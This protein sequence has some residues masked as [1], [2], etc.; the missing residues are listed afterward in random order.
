MKKKKRPTLSTSVLHFLRA[1]FG[2]HAESLESIVKKRGM[3]S[4]KQPTFKN[5][6]DF[7]FLEKN[8][9]MRSY[10][11]GPFPYFWRAALC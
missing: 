10:V 2:F 7:F 6:T 3:G 8:I 1:I 5:R 9:K 11:A 4:E